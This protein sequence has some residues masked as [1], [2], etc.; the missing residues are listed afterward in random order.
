MKH[1]SNS[2]ASQIRL[3]FLTMLMAML[4]FA[5]ISQLS[6]S[7]SHNDDTTRIRAIETQEFL[8]DAEL[9]LQYDFPPDFLASSFLFVCIGKFLTSAIFRSKIT[10][11]LTF[12]YHVSPRSP[13][14]H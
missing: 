5:F 1:T 9:T 14:L 6:P 13:P 3:L 4:G 8:H 12:L 11:R 7:Y 2:V 10:P